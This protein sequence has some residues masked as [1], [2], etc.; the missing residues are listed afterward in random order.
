MKIRSLTAAGLLLTLT[1]GCTT[2][3]PPDDSAADSGVADEITVWTV[4]DVQDRI[5]A[6]E[7]IIAGFTEQSGI[8]V[9]LVAISEAQFDKIVTTSAA[10]GTLPDVVAALSPAGVQSMAVSGLLDT[11]STG[12]VVDALGRDTF[13]PTALNLTRDNEEQVAVP[14]DAWTQLLFYR[15]DLFAKAGLG[16]PNTYA[17]I[18]AA[19]KKLTSGGKWGI[20]LS[21]KAGDPFT[22]QSFEHLALGNG[23]EMV[24][25]DGTV[26]LDSAA[27]KEAFSFYGDLAR[28]YSADGNQDVDTTRANYFAGKAA[29]VIWSTFLL[30]ELAGLRNDALPT[31]PECK[32]DPEFL[33]K[34]TGIVGPVSG[35]SGKPAQYG[36]V[37][38]WALTKAGNAAASKQ[39]VE[40]MMDEA[41]TD[42]LAIAPE[43]KVPVRKGTAGDP[44]KFVDAWSELKAGVDKKAPLT[45]FYSADVL[46]TLIDGPDEVAPWGFSQGQGALVGATNGQLPVAG[47]VNDMVNGTDPHRAAEQADAAV[48]EIA[49]SLK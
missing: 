32:G 29:M 15:K 1:V 13:S 3:A 4:E 22:H 6:T 16:T 11:K 30:D 36:R 17:K 9:N 35:P 37:T 23:C 26:T 18:E 25:R 39:F 45:D 10:G 20:A 14:S 47:A 40:Y 33:A 21:T 19:A 27:C 41:Y 24:D 49:E 8:K 43:G 48:T 12:E 28:N 2:G 34:N 38:S 44:R 7:K 46:E 42:W 31:C 5:T